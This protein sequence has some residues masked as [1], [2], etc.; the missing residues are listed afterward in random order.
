[1]DN[2][3]LRDLLEQK[4]RIKTALSEIIEFEDILG[5]IT[6]KPQDSN[7][8][9]TYNISRLTTEFPF[10]NWTEFFHSAFKDVVD[11][12]LL[13]S[14]TEVLIQ[15][16]YYFAFS[17]VF[18]GACNIDYRLFMHVQFHYNTIMSLPNCQTILMKMINIKLFVVKITVKT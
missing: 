7:N 15:V 5:N 8:L 4:D 11:I 17:S 16:S 2:L 6:E 18:L 1:M 12:S 13:S 10:L 14:S 9:V 3:N